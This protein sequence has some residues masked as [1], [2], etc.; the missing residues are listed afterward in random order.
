MTRQ[1][2]TANNRVSARV[3]EASTCEP[4]HAERMERTQ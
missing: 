4:E 2:E 3:A 1:P